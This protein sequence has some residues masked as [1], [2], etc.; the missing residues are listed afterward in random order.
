[1]AKESHKGPEQFFL[2]FRRLEAESCLET[3][4]SNLSLAVL[5]KHSNPNASIFV[6]QKRDPLRV[7]RR[8]SQ[9][10]RFDPLT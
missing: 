3:N 7:H 2:F 10:R 4:K 9:V 5:S 6:N 1:M 8:D